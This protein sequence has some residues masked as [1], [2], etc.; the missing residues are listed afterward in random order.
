MTR[1]IVHIDSMRPEPVRDQYGR[2]VLPDP[3]TGDKRSWTRAT[4]VAH[5][6][7]DEHG[8][9]QWKRRKV[10]EGAARRPDLLGEVP[11]LV[12]AI[13]EADHWR[14]AMPAKRRFDELCDQAAREAGAEDGSK[15][16][17]LL[18]TITE[19]ADAG[20]LHEVIDKVPAELLPDVEA[21]LLMMAQ[22]QIVRPPHYIER[23][24]IN[25]TIESAGTFDRLLQLP[26]GR[27]VVGDLKTQKSV[28]S[29]WL[30]IAIQLAEYA[31]ADVMLD[32]IGGGLVP[33]P[34]QLDK[35]R[36]VVMHLPVGSGK[37]TLYEI[38]LEIGW[39]AAKLAHEVREMRSASKSMGWPWVSPIGVDMDADD[40]PLTAFRDLVRPLVTPDDAAAGPS[41][42]PAAGTTGH[43]LYLVRAAEHPD[44]LRALWKGL[45]AEGLWTDELTAAAAARK[46]ELLEAS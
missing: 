32:P 39:E 28:D 30:S 43:L 4:T 20:R 46:A 24:V 10:L 29:G 26:D 17:T 37:C 23:I 35:T 12:R 33:L 18:H 7:N 38:D 34:A 22:T 31:N 6:L 44:A 25:R 15:L 36:G 13:E 1:D 3:A 5:T 11:T 2:Y 16:G 14:D 8:L 19:Y 9:T 40:G 27:L 45:S 41:P 42:L 21:Y